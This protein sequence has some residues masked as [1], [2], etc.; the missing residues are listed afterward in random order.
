VE[1]TT[2]ETAGATIA[3]VRQSIVVKASVERAFSVFTADF[4]SWWP[5]SH[6]IGKSPMKQ[7]IIENRVG[8][9]CYTQQED[10]TDCDWGTVT[11]WEPPRRFIMAWQIRPDWTYEPDIAKSSEVEVRFTKQADGQT[12]VDLEHRYFERH[13][14]GGGAMRAGVDS[15]NG[16]SSIMALLA[17]RLERES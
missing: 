12:R 4:D 10:G 9:R 13:G 15:P 8:G 16:W 14:T 3:P 17:A 6:H 2:T 7:A 11:A 5:R 1:T